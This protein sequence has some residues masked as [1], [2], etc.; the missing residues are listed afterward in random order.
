LKP[1]R[2]GRC[3]FPSAFHG[4]RP[5]ELVQ[6]THFVGLDIKDLQPDFSI[7]ASITSDYDALAKR[8]KW[9]HSNL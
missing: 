1:P 6:D 2:S 4:K 5:S 7:L 3:V 8:V 9:V